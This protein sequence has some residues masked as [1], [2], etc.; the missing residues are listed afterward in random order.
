[1]SRR[2]ETSGA[3]ALQLRELYR[4]ATTLAAD[5]A[6]TTGV[7]PTDLRAL[8]LL[9]A[10][11]EGPMTVGAL[12]EAL[13]LSSGAVSEL[14]DRLERAQLAQRIRD[15]AD[16][17]RVLVHLAPAARTFGREQLA[18]I[19]RAIERAIASAGDEELETVRRFMAVLL[20][21]SP[22]A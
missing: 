1:M 20:D 14:V 13:G 2:A 7:H 15:D 22:E 18:P 9:D 10:A 4:R 12:G 11:A 19:A 17:R 3:V 5:L 8:R 6:E 21:E 16:R